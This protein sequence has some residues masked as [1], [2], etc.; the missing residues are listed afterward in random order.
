METKALTYL[1]KQVDVVT[2][3]GSRHVDVDGIIFDSRKAQK[4]MLFIA[5]RGTQVDGHK[6]IDEVIAKGVTA[7]VCEEL[8]AEILKTVTYV[9][10]KHSEE[11]VGLIAAAYYDHP[12]HDLKLVGI[13]GTNGKTTT[14]TLLYDAARQLGYKAGLF[15][16]VV[17]YINGAKI[18]ATHT[19]PD[20]VELN[21]LLRQMVDEGCSYCFMEVSSH[22][23]VQQRIAGL[24][25]AGAIFS[26][27]THDHLDYHKTFEEYIRAKKL[28]FDNLS[29]DAFALTNIDDRNGKVMVQNTKASIHTYSLK[30]SSE[31]KCRIVEH[32]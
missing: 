13:T 25:F 8:P 26:N 5:V 3:K 29:F 16:T 14:A 28:F 7:I 17:N 20:A 10:V 24:K 4:G 31:F 27:I 1:L 11:A 9:Q 30:S 18:D 2:I 12:S 23:I 6:F 15:S 32:A 22:S 19:T 21:A